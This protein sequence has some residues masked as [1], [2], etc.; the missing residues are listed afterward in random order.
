MPTVR[1]TVAVAYEKSGRSVASRSFLRVLNLFYVCDNDLRSAKTLLNSSRR[2]PVCEWEDSPYPWVWFAW[3]G[4]DRVLDG[5][6]K[7]FVAMD[8]KQPF[9]YCGERKEVISRAPE[10]G[11]KARHTQGMPTAEVIAY[12]A[13]LS[14]AS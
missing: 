12:L 2:N 4:P 7:R 10:L 14:A 5:L 9:F 11:E 8:T 13:S 3:G 1:S 6:K